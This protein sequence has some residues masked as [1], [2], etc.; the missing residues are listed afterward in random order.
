MLKEILSVSGKPGLYKLVSQGKNMFIA[1]SLIDGKR[2]PVY[3]RDKVVSLGDIAIY[4]DED[5][6]PLGNVLEGIKT[7]EEG[8]E[9]EYASNIQPAE[10]RNYLGEVL[11]NFDRERV[12]PTDIKKIMAWYNLL[13]KN[14]LIDF[15]AKSKEEEAQDETPAKTDEKA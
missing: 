2:I 13:V 12:Y 4:T 9:I 11:P 7:K 6:I 1:E 14:N 10:L 8:K 3:A 5:D 15:S